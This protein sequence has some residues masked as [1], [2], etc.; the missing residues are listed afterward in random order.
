VAATSNLHQ[1]EPADPVASRPH[2]RLQSGIVKPKVY[3][4]GTVRYAN[5]CE[6][7]EP[8]SVDEAMKSK[9]W[10]NAIQAEFDAL[11]KNGTWTLVPPSRAMNLIDCKWVFKVMRRADGQVDQYKA[12]LVAKGFKQMYG[13]AGYHD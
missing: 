7:G 1:D 10:K 12:R 6:S 5:T 9:E 3:T 11:Q 8:S 4:D 2:T 13:I